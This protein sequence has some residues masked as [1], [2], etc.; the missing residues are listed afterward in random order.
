MTALIICLT[1]IFCVVW[2]TTWAKRMSKCGLPMFTYAA[3]ERTYADGEADE[4][5]V[6]TPIGFQLPEEKTEEQMSDVEKMNQIL[7]DTASTVSSL[8]RGEVDFDDIKN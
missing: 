7:S 8:L 3:C 2:L 6:E 1:I 5:P 4:E